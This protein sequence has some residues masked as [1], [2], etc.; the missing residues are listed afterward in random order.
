MAD[1][2]I[3]VGTGNAATLEPGAVVT[4]WNASIGGSQYTDLTDTDGTTP[5]PTLFADSN[6]AVP[7]FFGPD[8]VI[9]MYLD[10]NG[11]A[12][13]R[14]RTLTTSIRSYT[15][16]K[17]LPLAGGTRTGT[18]T[19]SLTASTSVSAASLVSTDTFDR[20]RRDAA[21]RQD[22]GD[23]A[24]ARDTNL[25]R[26]AANSL[27]TDD[28]FTVSLVFRHLGTTAGFYGAAAVA[29]PTVTGA[30]GG[31]A[32]LGSLI[33]ALVSLGLITDTTSA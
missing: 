24:T 8:D 5:L 20:Y 3:S 6:G 1:Y 33:S 9:E 30:K 18:V 19:A 7:E 10:A 27:K 29:K 32:A 15:D 13:P 16:A 4:C 25:Y 14:R 26:D 21:G 22:W 11:G 12:G 17:F 28:S 31:N 23:G 2:V